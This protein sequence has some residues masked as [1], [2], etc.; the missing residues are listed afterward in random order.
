MSSMLL[1][2]SGAGKSRT[3]LE[4][5]CQR[6]GLYLTCLVDSEGRGSADLERALHHIAEDPCFER[7]LPPTNYEDV[8]EANCAI[9]ESRFGEVLLARLCI[10]EF[11]CNVAREMSDGILTDEHRKLWVYL[12][13]QPTCI[14]GESDIFD[15]L[16]RKIMGIQG[17]HRLNL[18]QDKIRS[19]RVLL[20]TA[21]PLYCVL[22][23]A[24]IAAR[25]LPEAF[26]TFDPSKMSLRPSLREMARTLAAPDWIS[27]TLT[28]TALDKEMIQ[29][30]MASPVFKDTQAV[31]VTHFGAFNAPGEQIAY[32]KQFLPP[33]LAQGPSFDELCHRMPYWLKGRYRFTAAY[34]KDLLLVGF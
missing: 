26:M 23:E 29:E 28:G 34:I 2:T 7:K 1:N 17:S 11:F 3:V 31:T 5:L 13:I 12:Q 19:L 21:H 30:I 27:L 14:V 22:D 4:G 10:L 24:Q 16:T 15:T 32:L 8:H 33:E 9:A 18:V 6:W 20:G 25:S